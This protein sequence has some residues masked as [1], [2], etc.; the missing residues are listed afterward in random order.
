MKELVGQR[1]GNYR[2]IR[3]LGS[4]GF[5]NVYLAEHVHLSSLAAIK[6]LYNQHFLSEDD[7]ENF[8]NEALTIISL[9]HPHIMRILDFDIEDNVVFMVMEYAPNGTIR[10]LYPRGTKIPLAQIVNYV[11]QVAPALQY[12]HDH[13]IIHRDVKPENMLLNAEKEILLSD[14][15]IST[16]AHTTRSQGTLDIV[17]TVQYIAP[18]QLQGRAA[19][20]SDQYALGI[21]VYEW[22]TG[23]PPFT[24]SFVEIAT[25][26]LL[27]PPPPLREKTPKISLRIEQVVLKALEKDPKQR[28]PSVTAFAT[29]FEEAVQSALSLSP[30]ITF[31]VRQSISNDGNAASSLSVTPI[32][33]SSKAPSMDGEA[34]QVVPA[35]NDKL[36]PT[37]TLPSNA[38]YAEILQQATPS[39][40]DP[41]QSSQEVRDDKKIAETFKT[42]NNDELNRAQTLSLEPHAVDQ[43]TV[44]PGDKKVD[45]ETVPPPVEDEWN[46]TFNPTLTVT[47][48][49]PSLL[50]TAQSF[51]VSLLPTVNAPQGTKGTA[52]QG[53]T[54]SIWR[55]QA[56]EVYSIA[57]SSDN[58]Y[59]AFAGADKTI[60]LYEVSTERKFADYRCRGEVYD[61]AWSPDC[62]YIASAGEGKKIQLWNIATGREYFSYSAPGEVY[63]LAWSPDSKYI[64]SA[65][66]DG[67][68]HVRDVI[69]RDDFCAFSG[70][71]DWIRTVAWS[72]NGKYI[73]SGG[74]DCTIH[75]WDFTS[76]A[77]KPLVTFTN[78]TDWIRAV[79]WSPDGKQIASAG[80]DQEIYVWNATTGAITVP[81]TGHTAK[82]TGGV[83]AVVWSPD[84]KYIAS[85]GEDQTVQVWNPNDG[86][87]IFTY[88]GH[89]APVDALSW[90]HDGQRI[91][92]GS[93]D[94]TVQ[95]WQAVGVVSKKTVQ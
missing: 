7:F 6:V 47:P 3:L 92:S 79:T 4:G 59:V 66:V 45:E 2:L 48:K 91:A 56:Q 36:N 25:Q 22:L 95:I 39:V 60:Q 27:L 21:V 24:G 8:R 28:F 33:D 13:G 65:G 51:F 93:Y 61:I 38:S 43:L 83:L 16:I 14:F 72:H 20:A 30:N 18:E 26:Q 64:V 9:N 1:L 94:R 35:N 37:Q 75:I 23:E 34:S 71:T 29:A 68:L 76:R 55:S 11:L 17:G 85:A 15:G 73:A 31:P 12:A 49:N 40:K 81:Y 67:V 63:A 32:E 54:F 10:H 78:H 86:K 42:A 74:N 5:A 89:S 80:D 57:W 69:R 52:E 82:W 58:K 87:H 77:A 90:S 44:P 62:K 19:R 50:Q 46:Q 84:G 70:H 53:T 41:S 88:T